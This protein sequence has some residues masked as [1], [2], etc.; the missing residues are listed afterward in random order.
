MMCEFCT[1][2]YEHGKLKQHLKTCKNNPQRDLTVEELDHLHEQ[3]FGVRRTREGEDKAA[4]E[5]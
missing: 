1:Q 5:E 2:R 4:D 3:Q